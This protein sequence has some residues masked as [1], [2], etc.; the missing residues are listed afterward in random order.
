MLLVNMIPV[1]M[2][3]PC[4]L[5]LEYGHLLGVISYVGRHI[6]G[7]YEICETVCSGNIWSLGV[8]ILI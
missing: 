5:I 3:N 6:K 7:K 1:P 8:P 4:Y 2:V